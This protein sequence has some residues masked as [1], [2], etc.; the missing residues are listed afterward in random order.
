MT[1]IQCWA[2]RNLRK[3]F[4]LSDATPRVF[5]LM[6]ML[7]EVDTDVLDAIGA[8]VL[9][10][11]IDGMMPFGLAPQRWRPLTLFDGSEVLVPGNLR[12]YEDSN[13]DWLI[14][15]NQQADG[16]ILGRMP[17]GGSYYDYEVDNS[18][19]DEIVY[20]DLDT[21]TAWQTP[22]LDDA[23]LDNL[24]SC[25]KNLHE[26]TDKAIFLNYF[27]GGLGGAF[28]VPTWL[29]SL[30][31]NPAWTHEFHRR[32]VQ[33]H[34]Q[35]LARLLDHVAPYIEVVGISG[36]DWGTQKGEMFS[37]AVFA[38][39][40]TPYISQINKV[41]HDYGKPTGF[42]CCG[43]IRRLLP[44]FVKMGVD[45]LN[46]VQTTAANMDARQ[47]EN[48]FGNKFVFWGG[49]IDTQKTL[50]FGTVDDVRRE[51]AE[52]VSIF[53]A[54]GGFVFNTVHNIQKDCSGENVAAMYRTVLETGR[55]D[56]VVR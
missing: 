34:T 13:G 41:V 53:G 4:G 31:D 46:P 33:F 2:H 7:A 38:G 9:P 14:R 56:S 6:Q 18:V 40:Y 26:T 48:E 12:I 54:G 8:D 10:L 45:C 32:H 20:P 21:W 47:L 25:A 1:G 15:E 50:P 29:V 27:R 43:S 17:K 24:A 16:K 22:Q 35:N 39:L 37:P 42:H 49:G 11:Y 55:Y 30:V 5:D 28:S 51:T 23:I 19:P 44:E 36:T 52:R 3:A